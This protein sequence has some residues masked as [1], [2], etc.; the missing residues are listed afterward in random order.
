MMEQ[1]D[2]SVCQDNLFFSEVQ[3]YY[4]HRPF[5][6]DAS[7]PVDADQVKCLLI[8]LVSLPESYDLCK[9]PFEL[10]ILLSRKYI[11]IKVEELLAA[12][13]DWFVTVNQGQYPEDSSEI[14]HA[15]QL[16][17]NLFRKQMGERGLST[18]ISDEDFLSIGK[19][20]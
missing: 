7:R 2:D 11:S 5:Q 15:Q 12:L 13:D 19:K 17:E 14:L 6:R 20:N 3:I 9:D 16:M 18:D 1:I 10:L 8:I 4:P